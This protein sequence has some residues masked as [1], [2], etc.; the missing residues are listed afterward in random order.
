MAVTP[1]PIASQLTI[2]E[3]RSVPVDL[4]KAVEHWRKS[5]ADTSTRDRIDGLGMPRATAYKVLDPAVDFDTLQW[6]T[7]EKLIEAMGGDLSRALPGHASE[8]A[9][10]APR[11]PAI[12]P[13]A[14]G[15]PC[16]GT[17]DGEVLTL[18]AAA[19]KAYHN[20]P[21]PVHA[22]VAAESDVD[23]TAAPRWLNITEALAAAD[24]DAWH[25]TKGRAW[26]L[27]VTGWAFVA[28]YA[29]R[30]G[31][32]LIM[33]Q[34]KGMGASSEPRPYLLPNAQG[35]LE[36]RCLALVARPRESF[37]TEYPLDPR[38]EP[39]TERKTHALRSL[40]PAYASVGAIT[41]H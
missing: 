20:K 12:P 32:Y 15:L 17:T 25:A 16:L 7:V 22:L 2:Y 33:R 35:E 39:R 28:R 38:D 3:R 27:A 10:R 29:I 14:Y 6:R 8:A 37:W 18:N 4:K 19:L 21:E 13:E 31:G 34:Y 1:E 26:L 24:G 23:Y 36:L 30:P 40:T 41:P 11:E 9:A 5:T